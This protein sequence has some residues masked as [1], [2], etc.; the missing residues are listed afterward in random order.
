M[1]MKKL[2]MI[3]SAGD[4]RIAGVGRFAGRLADLWP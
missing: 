4:L 3:A 2:M 1:M